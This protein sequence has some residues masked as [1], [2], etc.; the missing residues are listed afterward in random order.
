M[1]TLARPMLKLYV[2]DM[3]DK[4]PEAQQRHIRHAREAQF[5][6]TLEEVHVYLL[7][8]CR[9]GSMFCLSIGACCVC[10]CM[11]APTN[12]SS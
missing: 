6:M 2:L 7:A 8:A 10:A 4:H 9:H 5:G 11:P 1:G 12:G 3:H